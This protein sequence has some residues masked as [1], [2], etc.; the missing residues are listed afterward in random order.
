MYMLFI[1]ILIAAFEKL[2][3]I[4]VSD[5][6]IMVIQLYYVCYNV[7]AWYIPHMRVYVCLYQYMQQTKKILKKNTKNIQMHDN[8]SHF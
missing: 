4:F 3:T 8:A 6:L 7:Y 1:I 2:I 5:L